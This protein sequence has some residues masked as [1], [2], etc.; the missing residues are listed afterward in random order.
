MKKTFLFNI[1]NFYF[2]IKLE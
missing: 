2:S 1:F